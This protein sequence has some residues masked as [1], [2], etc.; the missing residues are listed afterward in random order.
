MGAIAH[1]PEPMGYCY[2]S[3][4]TPSLVPWAPAR[5]LTLLRPALV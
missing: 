4:E 2:F 1:L 5:F 3:Y